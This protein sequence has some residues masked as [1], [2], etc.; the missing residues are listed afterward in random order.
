MRKR[1]GA[2]S[3]PWAAVLTIALALR[4]ISKYSIVE[5]GDSLTRGAK[6]PDKPV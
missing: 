5:K 6:P 3:G 2:L 1:K 4:A